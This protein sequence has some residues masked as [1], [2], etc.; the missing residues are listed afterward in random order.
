MDAKQKQLKGIGK[1]KVPPAA[2]KSVEK[3]KETKP[4]RVPRMSCPNAIVLTDPLNAIGPRGGPITGK[5]ATVAAPP[6]DMENICMVT[7]LL[8]VREPK[9]YLTLFVRYWETRLPDISEGRDKGKTQK[10]TFTFQNTNVGF[11][12][13][14]CIYKPHLCFKTHIYV[15]KPTF[16]F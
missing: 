10:P 5:F 11:K 3:E 15:L 16:M 6:P 12:T 1:N 7:P 13:H 9:K 4:V 2:E 8:I 14:I